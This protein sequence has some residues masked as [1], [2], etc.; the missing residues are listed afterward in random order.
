MIDLKTIQSAQKNF[1]AAEKAVLECEQ[2]LAALAEL[3]SNEC[4]IQ[5]VGHQRWLI[6]SKT[7]PVIQ[8]G[9]VLEEK[10]GVTTRISWRQAFE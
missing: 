2:N 5:S 4:I 10:T 1:L 7:K 8:I 3:K 9:V 6:S